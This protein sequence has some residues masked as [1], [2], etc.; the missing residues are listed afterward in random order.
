MRELVHGLR[1]VATED[2]IIRANVSPKV[3][4]MVREEGATE[5]HLRVGSSPICWP[6][7]L[8]VDMSTRVELIASGLTVEEIGRK[9]IRADSLGYLSIEGMIS[10]TGLPRENFCLG[11]FTGDYPVEPCTLY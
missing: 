4:A 9:I 1:V 7:F 11:C 5:V 3:V 8:G 2:S 10:A 6:C